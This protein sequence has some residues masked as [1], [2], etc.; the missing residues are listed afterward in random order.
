MKRSVWSRCHRLLMANPTIDDRREVSSIECCDRGAKASSVATSVARENHGYPRARSH[1]LRA[2]QK[3]GQC[4]VPSRTRRS[5]TAS[6]RSP[7]GPPRQGSSHRRKET[8]TARE[9]AEATGKRL[10]LQGVSVGRSHS[11]ELRS[12][13]RRCVLSLKKGGEIIGAKQRARS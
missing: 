8:Q 4:S 3:C 11:P 2:L 10:P 6:A 5:A 1:R 12:S 9:P 13:T 7:F